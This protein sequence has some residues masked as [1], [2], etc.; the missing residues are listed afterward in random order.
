MLDYVQMELSIRT[1][2]GAR[3]NMTKT[4]NKEPN[5]QRQTYKVPEAAKV[6]GVGECAIRKG[7]AAGT[8]PHIRFGR[9]IL[10][11][12][13]AFLRWLDSCGQGTA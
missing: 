4:E 6:A 12:K 1:R 5:S 7:V 8:I 2:Q 9:N 11:P 13:T 3:E 10:I